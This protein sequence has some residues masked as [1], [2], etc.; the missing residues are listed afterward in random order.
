[1]WDS[2]SSSS[3]KKPV[4]RKGNLVEGEEEKKSLFNLP[5]G[6]STKEEGEKAGAGGKRTREGKRS[7][8]KTPRAS[9]IG[10]LRKRNPGKGRSVVLSRVW[11]LKRERR[12]WIEE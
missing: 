8:S 1:M 2:G 9:A 11:R 5:R 3:D 10:A 6:L 4:A 7:R 12:E